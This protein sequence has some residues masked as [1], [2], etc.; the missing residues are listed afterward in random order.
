M[1]SKI[2]ITFFLGGLTG[3]LAY[4]TWLSVSSSDATSTKAHWRAIETYNAYIR[5]PSNAKSDPQTGLSMVE[6]VDDIEPHLAALVAAGELRHLDIVLP[7]V[8]NTNRAAKRH[9]M[10][11]CDRHH[12]E[13]IVHASGN[14]SYVAFPTKGKQPLHLNIWYRKTSESVVQQLISELEDL[15]SGEEPTNS[16]T[17]PE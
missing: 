1:K 9:W 13:G 8:S 4:H 14:P 2:I 5:D 11:F 6:P 16:S 3:G 12:P 10:R 15:G 7:T 17:G